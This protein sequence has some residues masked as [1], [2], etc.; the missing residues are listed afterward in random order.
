MEAERASLETEMPPVFGKEMDKLAQP[1]LQTRVSALFF[2]SIFF[3]STGN[4]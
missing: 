4:A 2:C 3:C 1:I